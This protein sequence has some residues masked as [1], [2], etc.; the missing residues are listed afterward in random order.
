[1]GQ[2][3]ANSS[4]ALQKYLCFSIGMA[5]TMIGTLASIIRLMVTRVQ[6]SLHGPN[7]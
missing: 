4:I 7:G 3:V 5:V 1:M 6:I 2:T